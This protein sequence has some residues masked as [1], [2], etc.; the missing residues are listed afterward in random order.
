[1]NCQRSYGESN[2]LPKN[3]WLRNVTDL[4]LLAVNDVQQI[5]WA[6]RMARSGSARFIREAAGFSASEVARVVGVS[7]ATVSRWER[8]ERIPRADAA[9]RWA[10]LLRKLSA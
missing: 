10:E 5:A 8:G 2:Q 4:T 3:L 9:E 6:R 1:M 7:P